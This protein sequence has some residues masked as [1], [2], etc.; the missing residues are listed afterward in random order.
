MRV[1]LTTDASLTMR[2]LGH[3]RRLLVA[4]PALANQAQEGIGALAGLPTLGS[5]DEP[6]EVL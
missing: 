1:D 3:S 2:T 5:A 6:G 4:S